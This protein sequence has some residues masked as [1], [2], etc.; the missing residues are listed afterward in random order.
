MEEKEKIDPETWVDEH[1]DYLYRFALSRLL[2]PVLAE[3]LVQETFVGALKSR[4][5][6]RGQASVKTWLVGILKHKIVDHFRKAGR[7]RP[8]ES[9]ENLQDRQ[10]DLFDESGEWKK[11][12][13]R[14]QLDPEKIQENKEFWETFRKC[15][16]GLPP[17]QI[18]LFTLRELDGKKSD[19]ICML[20]DITPTNLWVMLYRARMSMR[21]CL[22]ENWFG[23]KS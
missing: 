23:V 12:P 6:F 16:L 17:K 15:L 8:Y 1:G 22:E 10:A 19:E 9:V 7:E 4:E 20:L 11:G 18:D 2:D 13:S 5:S 3:E 14:W 21:T